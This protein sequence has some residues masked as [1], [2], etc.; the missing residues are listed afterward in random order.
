MTVTRIDR[1][2]PS[3]ALFGVPADYTMAGQPAPAAQ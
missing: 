3:P 2:E 1:A